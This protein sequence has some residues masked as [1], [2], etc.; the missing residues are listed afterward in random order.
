MRQLRSAGRADELLASKLKA[1]M[2]SIDRGVV[3]VIL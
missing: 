3:E 2:E 1:C